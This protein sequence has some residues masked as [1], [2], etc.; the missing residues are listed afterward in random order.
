MSQHHSLRLHWLDPKDPDQAFPPPALALKEPDGLLAVGGD[1]STKRLI[2]AYRA[3]I[4][5][6]FNPDEPILWWSPDPRCVFLPD[7]IRVSHSLAKRIRQR[8]FA[9]SI[10]RAFTEVVRACGGPRRVDRGTWLSADMQ[11]AYQALHGLGLAH[12][13]EVWQHGTL[14]GGLYGVSMGGVFF[15]ESM[16]SSATDASK[17]ALVMLA[18]QL[19]R[20]GFVMI[21]AQVESPHLMSLGA[22]SLPRAEFLGLLQQGLQIAAPR[23]WVLDAEHQGNAAHLPDPTATHP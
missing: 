6:W 4:F 11:S 12:S 16:F 21:D 9:L 2:R 1:L 15:G 22:S 5:P 18:A 3:G 7:S 20:W 10:D 23:A 8:P 13:L 14:V 17:I 19:R